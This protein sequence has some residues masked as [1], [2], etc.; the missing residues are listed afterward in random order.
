[1]ANH[2]FRPVTTYSTVAVKV[3]NAFARAASLMGW[4]PHRNRAAKC[5]LGLLTKDKYES[6][7]KQY[8]YNSRR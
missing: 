1:M 3:E 5:Y 8:E 2:H 6:T 7:I 4:R